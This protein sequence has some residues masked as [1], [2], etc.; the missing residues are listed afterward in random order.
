MLQ[1]KLIN[2]PDTPTWTHPNNSMKCIWK[3]IGPK[4]YNQDTIRGS[5]FHLYKCWSVFFHV[6]YKRIVA[7]ASMTCGKLWRE[8]KYS[9]LE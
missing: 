3:I 8:N 9:I 1:L 4:L 2:R 7:N 5:L 6:G